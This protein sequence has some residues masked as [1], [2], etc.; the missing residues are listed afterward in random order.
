[1]FV[2]GSNCRISAVAVGL[3]LSS[4]FGC[5]PKGIYAKCWYLACDVLEDIFIVPWFP[6]EL[7]LESCD[8]LTQV[9]VSHFLPDQV[10]YVSIMHSAVESFQV[11]DCFD[12]FGDKLLEFHCPFISIGHGL[13][14]SFRFVDVLLLHSSVLI[15]RAK[16]LDV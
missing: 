8:V 5:L 3:F 4:D 12:E 16:R 2:M 15:S 11:I 10:D 13:K 1:M 6:L 7:Y 9:R 14:R